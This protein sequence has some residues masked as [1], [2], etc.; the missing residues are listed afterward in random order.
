[1]LLAQSS[2][3]DTLVPYHGYARGP[4]DG[5]R[6]SARTLAR[7]RDEARVPASMTE[8]PTFR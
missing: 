2:K 4:M 3:W 6:H 1:M 8:G 5:I 7:L